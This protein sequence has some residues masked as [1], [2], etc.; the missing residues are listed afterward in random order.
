MSPA[1]HGPERTGE[2]DRVRRLARLLDR[3]VRLPGLGVRFGLDSI[4]GLLPGG[5]DLAMGVASGY[6]LLAAARHGAPRWLLLR[7]AA[8]IAIDTVVGAVPVL[9]DL[10]DVAWKSNTRNVR[11]LEAYLANPDRERRAGRGFLILLFVGLGLLIVGGIAVAVLLAR[12]VV[13]LL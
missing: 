10:F 4:V 5:G 12:A 9:G 2:L 3:A 7:M 11:L 13:A 1:V 8:N 6:I